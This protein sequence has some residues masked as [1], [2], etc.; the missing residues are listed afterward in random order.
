MWKYSLPHPQVNCTV[1]PGYKEEDQHVDFKTVWSWSSVLTSVGRTCAVLLRKAGRAQFDAPVKTNKLCCSHCKFHFRSLTLKLSF[2]TYCSASERQ[3]LSSAWMCLSGPDHC[4][5]S[6]RAYFF[7]WEK[8]KEA[9]FSLQTRGC[10]EDHAH[11]GRSS[12]ETRKWMCPNSET[13]SLKY[14]F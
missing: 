2:F 13:A 10:S 6:V 8:I 5:C 11:T 9:T 14:A 1:F 4:S 3:W 12:D 7:F